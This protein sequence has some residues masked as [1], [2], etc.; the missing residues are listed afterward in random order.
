M[1]RVRKGGGSGKEED[2]DGTSVE[3]ALEWIQAVSLVTMLQARDV[4]MVQC[5]VY[6][7]ASEFCLPKAS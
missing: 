3:E 6:S 4:R 2:L 7:L 1:G 5:F